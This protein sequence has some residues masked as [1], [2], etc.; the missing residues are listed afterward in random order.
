LPG[1]FA[2]E[3]VS[4]DHALA[5]KADGN[6]VNRSLASHD[7]IER[8]PI[9][10]CRPYFE[11]IFG[12]RPERVGIRNKWLDPH[13]WLQSFDGQ[14]FASKG[15]QKQLECGQALLTVDDRALLH[16]ARWP[17]DLLQNDGAKEMWM[18]LVGR[19]SKD[20]VRDVRNVIPEWFPL[21]RL[22][23]DIR[24]LEEGHDETLWLHEDHLWSANLGLQRIPPQ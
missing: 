23:P 15:I 9:T 20:S 1:L 5:S 18:M 4:L 3:A 2:E 13:C 16:Q 24:S 8:G 6:I 10:I 19:T 22:G 7:G 21:V 12:F 14:K 11:S 17:L